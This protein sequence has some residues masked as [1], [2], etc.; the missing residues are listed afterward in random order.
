MAEVAFG[1]RGAQDQIPHFF[2]FFQGYHHNI[3][4]Q[5]F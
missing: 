5:G 3:F 1:L 4:L 2:S